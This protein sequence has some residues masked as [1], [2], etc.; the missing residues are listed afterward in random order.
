MLQLV[1]VRDRLHAARA[2]ADPPGLEV[3]GR[4]RAFAEPWRSELV[5]ERS[6]GVRGAR[7]HREL[8][9]IAQFGV[10]ESFVE[11]ADHVRQVATAALVRRVP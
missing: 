3:V 4:C 1:E 6:E 7:V 8:G 9:E 10:A 2:R 5:Q 11:R